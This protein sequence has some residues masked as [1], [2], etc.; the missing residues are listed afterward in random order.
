MPYTREQFKH[1]VMYD[2]LE[3]LDP[4][5]VLKAFGPEAVLKAFGSEQVLKAF[6]PE[7]RLKGLKSEDRLK[8]LRPDDVMKAFAP[9]DRLKGLSREE[10]E[11]YLN[12]MVVREAA[13]EEYGAKPDKKPAKARPASRSSARTRR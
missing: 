6:D 3:E 2:L 9:E 5:E 4:Q 8:G 10:I 12:G 7:T 13:G 11:S 1:D